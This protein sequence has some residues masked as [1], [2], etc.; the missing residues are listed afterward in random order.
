MQSCVLIFTPS[1]H[2]GLVVARLKRGF[3]VA[4][5]VL[6]ALSLLSGCDGKAKKQ[7][8]MDEYRSGLLSHPDE[9]IGHYTEAIRINPNFAKAYAKR[10]EAYKRKGKQD[11][12]MA[13][14][15]EAIR[16]NPYDPG[17]RFSRG[18]AYFSTGELDKAIADYTEAIQNRPEF[19]RAYEPDGM[20]PKE[21]IGYGATQRTLTQFVEIGWRLLE[22]FK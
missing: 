15:T 9:A 11:K 12:A 17:A 13:D 21:F 22:G 5:A 3:P 10:G 7:K 20:E 2:A 16:L 14:F 4:L 6:V 1:A 8:A 18:Q 19:V